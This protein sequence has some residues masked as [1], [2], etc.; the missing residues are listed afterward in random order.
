[1]SREILIFLI[2]LAIF[3]GCITRECPECVCPPCPSNQSHEQLDRIKIIYLIPL[4]CDDC[5]LPMLQDIA[6]ELEIKSE[7]YIT[8]AVK[9]P[10]ALIM[11]DNR[12]TLAV[13]NSKLNIVTAICEFTGNERACSMRDSINSSN[14]ENCLSKYNISKNSV[15]FFHTEWCSH[16]RKMVP[17]IE[18]LENETYEFVWIDANDDERMKIVRECLAQILDK[19][20]YVPQFA[21]PANSK[22][23]IGEFR[24]IDE[25]RKFA[26]ECRNY[27]I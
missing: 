19:R 16:C 22:L 2:V 18:K 5:N 20:G 8:D 23:H 13:A 1:M 7:L 25:M 27:S 4:N 14:M 26:E 24:T 9:R 17:W 15:I 12:A 21:C 6:Y 11:K 3:S 10:S